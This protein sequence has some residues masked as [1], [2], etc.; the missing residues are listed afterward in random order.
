M[1]NGAQIA[2]Y[3][4]GFAGVYGLMRAPQDEV[5][6]GKLIWVFACGRT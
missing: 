2:G 3:G 1:R 6:A 4:V 5:Q